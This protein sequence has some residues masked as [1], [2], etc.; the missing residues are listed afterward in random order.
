MSTVLSGGGK[1]MLCSG[2]PFGKTPLTEAGDG[3][4]GD[5]WS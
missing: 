4:E 5:T 1:E 2:F 3:S